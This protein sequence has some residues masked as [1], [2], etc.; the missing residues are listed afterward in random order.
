MAR[1]RP[2]KFHTWKVVLSRRG[3][4]ATWE[5]ALVIAT[6]LEEAVETMMEHCAAPRLDLEVVA[7][8]RLPGEV[9]TKST[10]AAKRIRKAA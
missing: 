3:E 5:S 8:E 10:V 2:P 9:I 6:T 4:Q 7:V 1:S